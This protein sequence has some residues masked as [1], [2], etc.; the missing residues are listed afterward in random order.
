MNR[1]SLS[2]LLFDTRF[3]TV[4]VANWLIA[5]TVMIIAF[6]ALRIVVSFLRRRL[7]HAAEHTDSLFG[8]VAAVV[9]GGTSNTLIGLVA[10]LI[11]VGLLDLPPRWMERVSSLWFIVVALQVALWANRAITL[12]ME[13][14][15][16][17]SAGVTKPQLSALASLMMWGAKVFLWAI[18]LLAMLSNLGVNI[19]AFV[20]SL[21]V[22]GI[23]VALAVQ[24]ILGD[25]FAS[26]SIA[27]DKPFEVGDFI[28]VGSQSGTVEH[29]GLKTTR[30]R[31]LGGEQIVMANTAMLSSTVQNYKRLSERRVVFKFGLTY[32]CT[33]EQARQVPGIVERIIRGMDKTRFDRSHFQGFGDSSLDFETVYIVLDAGYNT[34]MDIQQEINL[35]LMT[36]FAALG[37]DFAFPTQTIH[38]AS[39][40]TPHRPQADVPVAA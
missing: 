9:V 2:E 22:G 16:S 14:Y 1:E 39:V 34:Y 11:G 19:T 26:L 35:Q 21:G 37:V 28:V 25:L 10:I 4:T 24:N 7:A 38:V 15:V 31:S 40:P 23:A 8:R 36:E 29:V 33:A 17:R 6:F 30:I 13:H 18:L 12:G 20:A 27:V 32:D 3:L 5:F